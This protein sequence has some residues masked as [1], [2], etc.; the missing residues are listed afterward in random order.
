MQL[1][2]I[3]LQFNLQSDYHRTTVAYVSAYDIPVYSMV[4]GKQI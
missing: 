3:I 2:L 4:Q 1:G